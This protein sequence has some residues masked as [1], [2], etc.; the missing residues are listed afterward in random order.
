MTNLFAQPLAVLPY[1]TGLVEPPLEQVAAKGSNPLATPQ[2]A[3][4]IGDPVPIVFCR[5]RN[6]VGGVFVSPGAT[7]GRYENNDSTNVLT[8]NLQIVLSEGDM[9]QLEERDLY[10][11]NC[12]VGTWAQTYNRRAGTFLP[13]NFIVAVATRPFWSCPVYCGTSGTYADMTTLSY[14]NT[15]NDNDDTWD[16][17]VHAFVREGLLVT[18]VLD[19]TL[20][21]SDNVID[22]S[23]YLIE[24]SSR[25]PL[26]LIDN[27]AMLESANFTDVNG[28]FYNGEFKQSSN[29]EDWLQQIS[30]AFLL[31][32]S[33]KAGKKGFKPRLPINEDYTIKTTAVDWVYTF[34]EEDV[35][36]DGFEIE[37]ISLVDRRPI[38]AQVLWRQQP[39]GDIG[40][41]RTAE[42]RMEG[43]A[44]DGP[45]EQYDL[46][47]F[48]SSENHAVKVGAFYVAKRKYI[49]HMLRLQVKPSTF[50][51]TLTLGDIVRVQLKREST[52]GDVTLY[53]YVYEVERINRDLSGQVGLDLMHFPID[54]QGRSLVAI[55]VA[56][57]TAAGTLLPTGRTDFSCNVNND[58]DALPD[59]GGNLPDLPSLPPY[60]VPAGSEGQPGDGPDNPP[61]PPE[62]AGLIEGASGPDETPIEDDVLT[63]DAPCSGAFIEW[64]LVDAIGNRTKISEGVA[65]SYIVQP[66]DIDKQV[67]GIGRC[68]DPGSPTGF[69]APIESALT[70]PV[71]PDISQ[72]SSVRWTGQVNDSGQVNNITTCFILISPGDFLTMG[73]SG[74]H[75]TGERFEGIDQFGY[76]QG[77]PIGPIPWRSSVSITQ[78]QSAPFGDYYLGSLGKNENGNFFGVGLCGGAPNTHPGARVQLGIG[79]LGQFATISGRWE[80][81]TDQSTV[82]VSWAGRNN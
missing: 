64:F 54:D 62:P 33:D 69:G 55:A 19:S 48:C 49:T 32:I 51:S 70:N 21:S 4:V 78:I 13:G 29:L 45:F 6:G 28:L 38:T 24:K 15:H 68:P 59:T 23:L 57:I 79:L 10:Q 11:R 5:R 37:Y 41:I 42:V 44:I 22:L 71:E 43:E 34:T 76:M 50:N 14:T 60:E 35:M 1:E 58:T 65:A 17:Q 39:D 27:A 26:S 25:L 52:P 30:T 46:S 31:R 56:G 75:G 3:I 7:E 74:Y 77:V 20:G 8:V 2:R 36:A 61:E 82:A 81:S 9:P 12:R 67:L 72:Y 53:D 16:K 80:F 40:L 73:G 66:A 63:Y 47:Q 18:R